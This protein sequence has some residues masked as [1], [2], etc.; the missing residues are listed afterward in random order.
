MKKTNIATNALTPYS[1]FIILIT[2]FIVASLPHPVQAGLIPT[3]TPMVTYEKSTE[4]LPQKHTEER[5]GY[6]GQARIG[7]RILGLTAAYITSKYDK[8]FSDGSST[9]VKTEKIRAGGSSIIGSFFALEAKAGA[10]ALKET[11]T[12]KDSAGNTT[13]TTGGNRLIKP[14]AGANAIIHLFSMAQFTAGVTYTFV[15]KDHWSDLNKQ[16]EEFNAGFVIHASL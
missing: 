16:R 11:R 7:W 9:H 12:N 10:E 3:I 14:Y 15:D 6:G 2:S 13:S 5:V 1:K 8:S 4:L